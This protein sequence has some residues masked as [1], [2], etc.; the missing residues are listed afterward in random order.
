VHP[1]PVEPRPPAARWTGDPAVLTSRLLLIS[2]L[3]CES[4]DL[5]ADDR[6]L[7]VA[8]GAGNAALAAARRGCR[9]AGVDHDPALLARARQR[10]QADGLTVTFEQGDVEALPFPD[11]CFEVVLLAGEGLFVPDQER[12]T[13][14]L[15]R[16]CRPG[17]AS[18][19]SA[20]PPMA[21]WV[22][23]WRPWAGTCRQHRSGRLRCRGATVSGCG[24]CSDPRWRSPPRGG[25]FSGG[26]R[27][28]STRW[29]S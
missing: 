2:E 22:R 25:P 15:L 6:V 13:G 21:T 4:V 23:C 26:S 5:H 16:V 29:R 1:T 17:G 8:C 18:A 12:T 7:D 28:S 11:G 14:E 20:G 9:V 24:S 19:W 3:L 10:A 27:P